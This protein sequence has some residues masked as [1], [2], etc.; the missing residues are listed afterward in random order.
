[1]RCRA[2]PRPQRPGLPGPSPNAHPPPPI[3]VL[4]GIDIIDIQ[5]GRVN[6]SLGVGE[7]VY[8]PI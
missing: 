2:G 4:L 1:M 6:V 3:T 8:N 7:H 5:P